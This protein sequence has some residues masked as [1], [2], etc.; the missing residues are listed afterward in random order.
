MMKNLTIERITMV[1]GGRHMRLRLRSGRFGLNA[2]YFSANPAAVSIQTGDVVDIAFTPQVNEFRGERSVQM[3]VQDIRPSCTAECSPETAAYH[4][5]TKGCLTR[6]IAETLLPERSTL[7]MV[8]R[9]LAA[10]PGGSLEESPLCLC[11]KIVR[12]TNQPMN[13]SQLLTCLDI[14]RDVGLLE[15]RN[16]HKYITI[17]LTA[18]NK[19]ADL[20]TSLTM[21]RLLRAKES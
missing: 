16:Q 2:I 3:N 13:L 21:Q 20:T 19:K 14:F 12:W 15:I 5:L 11:R 18:G 6:E 8:W 7:A 4:A 10:A 1:G 17:R 9:Y